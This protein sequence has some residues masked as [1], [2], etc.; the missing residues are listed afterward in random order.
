MWSIY[1]G[2]QNIP[3][4]SN[5]DRYKSRSVITESGVL[6]LISHQENITSRISPLEYICIK[7]PA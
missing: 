7:L 1:Y 2:K 6:T 4:T 3:H 5:T